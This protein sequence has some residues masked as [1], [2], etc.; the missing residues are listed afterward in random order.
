MNTPQP[1]SWKGHFHCIYPSLPLS[2]PPELLDRI[3]HILYGDLEIID[4][5]TFLE[6]R[7]KGAESAGKGNAVLSLTGFF[8]WLENANQESDTE[9]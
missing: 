7:D 3:F 1:Y 8:Q 9:P 4:E 2:L 5:A 6:W